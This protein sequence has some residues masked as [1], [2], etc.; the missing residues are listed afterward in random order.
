MDDSRFF[1]FQAPN[2]DSSLK[3]GQCGAPCCGSRGF[4][5]MTGARREEM[6]LPNAVNMDR[7]FE[8]TRGIRS[9]RRRS[10]SKR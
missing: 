5:G 4:M 3:S 2:L 1:N 7:T 10:K 9:Q 8:Q 6:S